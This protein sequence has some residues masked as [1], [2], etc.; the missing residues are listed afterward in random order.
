MT[1]MMRESELR[2]Y[3]F[4]GSTGACM[5]C[6]NI[7]EGVEPD[8]SG[9]VCENCG[10]DAVSGVEQLL[11]EGRIRVVPDPDPYPYGL[12]PAGPD[13]TAYDLD[14]EPE[15]PAPTQ[16]TLDLDEEEER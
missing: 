10:A 11:I 13:T 7:Q 12:A 6:G 4:D 14:P 8:A 2:R 5:V 9:Y 3:M 16:L 15:R 1:L